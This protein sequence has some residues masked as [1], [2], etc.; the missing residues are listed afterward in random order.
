MNGFKKQQMGQR[1]PRPVAENGFN[2]DI[3]V[4]ISQDL[5]TGRASISIN[6][7]MPFSYIAHLLIEA[8]LN[9]IKQLINQESRLV[10]PNGKG[11][12]VVQEEVGNAEE[13][14]M[15]TEPSET[16]GLD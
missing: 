4:T 5:T 13:P 7:P 9:N 6:K 2:P 14:A 11:L 8:G 3:V 10:D 1:L 16:E 15:P 12:S